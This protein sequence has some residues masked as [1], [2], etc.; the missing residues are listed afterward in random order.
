MGKDG[1]REYIK[2]TAG[3]GGKVK[4]GE[5]EELG[6]RGGMVGLENVEDVSWPRWKAGRESVESGM[7]D[8]C[9]E[10]ESTVDEG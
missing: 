10:I 1:E 6:S 7:R 2:D 5:K 4:K 8:S 3:L 9:K